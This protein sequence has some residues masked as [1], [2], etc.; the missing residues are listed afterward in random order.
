HDWRVVGALVRS[1]ARGG[2]G[3]R[4]EIQPRRRSPP[5]PTSRG[6]VSLSSPCGGAV[7]MNAIGTMT[8]L[9]K[10]VRRFLRV[11]GQT[12]LSPLITTTL[13]FLVFGYSIGARVR[14][15]QGVPYLEFIVPGL[16]FLGIANNAFLNSS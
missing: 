9:S 1:Q 6:S 2:R 12:V 15:V 16:V 3:G 7:A 14:E 8:L 11:P 5:S 4:A 13:Y 10:E